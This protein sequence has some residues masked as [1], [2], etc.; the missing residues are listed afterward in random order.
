VSILAG[1]T[2]KVSDDSSL[3]L[4][5]TI[6]NNG[7]IAVNGLSALN[8]T[9]IRIISPT[10]TL[11]GTGTVLM[12]NNRNNQITAVNSAFQLT[13]LGN[14]ITGA[15]TI[16][17]GSMELSNS[18]TIIASQGTALLLT[19]GNGNS[20]N[21][22][23]GKMFGK[24]AGGLVM[25]SGIFTNS[26][27]VEADNASSVSYAAG[28]IDTN[29]AEGV[30]AGGTWRAVATGGGATLQVTGGM[31]VTDAATIVLSGAGSVFQ[32]GDGN[33]FTTLENSLTTIAAAGQLQVLAS[34]GFTAANAIADSGTVQLGGG[35]FHAT[36][37]SIA[38]GGRLFGFGT[39]SN[40]PSNSGKIEAAGGTLTV[41]GAVGGAGTLQADSAAT[42]TL[43]AATNQA[44]T[45]VDNGTLTL[46]AGAKLT[47]TA[48]VDPT[49]TGLFQLNAS[50][51]L[52]IAADLGAS[53]KISFL[54]SALLNIEAA[55]KWGTNVGLSSYTGPTIQHFV[56]GDKIDLKDLAIAGL[57][58]GYTA[59]TGLLQ[60]SSPSAAATLAFDNATLGAGTFT[61]AND[62]SGHTLVTLV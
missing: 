57:T 18:G 23:A 50:A 54:G 47:V 6:S 44:A 2:V 28:A 59:A 26:G 60:L 15:G 10:L 53:N 40:A 51:T 11:T 3:L 48:A 12:S 55:A 43:N 19:M 1:S 58:S 62:G 38:A 37:L 20:V 35:T 4:S 56:S 27:I 42:L 45:V 32:A 22:A 41:T 5:G 7:T 52:D 61:L 33:N 17:A 9:T 13:N 16:G 25:Q 39:L 34:R 24:G 29:N 8:P 46:A 49:S 21:T 14:T 36:S 30:L 31:V